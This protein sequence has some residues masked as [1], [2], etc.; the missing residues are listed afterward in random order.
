MEIIINNGHLQYFP[1]FINT[2]RAYEYFRTLQGLNWQQAQVRYYRKMVPIPRLQAWYGDQLC[3]YQYSGISLTAQPWSPLLL[4]LKQAVEAHSAVPFNSV[5]ANYYRDQHDC[6][7]W[8]SDDEPELGVDP[9]IASLSFGGERA[10]K[11]KHKLTGETMNIVL[12]AGDLLLMSGSTQTY[13]LHTIARTKTVKAARINLT[14][15]KII[16]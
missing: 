10:F 3:D 9:V 15:R 13:W 6:V 8:H 16:R 4:T 14:F 11:M 12:K 2:A 1:N 7:A 5:L